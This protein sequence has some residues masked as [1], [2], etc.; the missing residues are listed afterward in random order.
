VLFFRPTILILNVITNLTMKHITYLII[1]VLLASCGNQ[2]VVDS[3][4]RRIGESEEAQKKFIL[5]VE[6][7]L[8]DHGVE[9]QSLLA[10]RDSLIAFTSSKKTL[11]NES[12]N[13]KSV[14]SAVKNWNEDLPTIFETNN[15][16]VLNENL[17]T[18][19]MGIFA[20]FEL[21][22]KTNRVLEE[23]AKAA[24]PKEAR[25]DFLKLFFEPHLTE[26]KF[27]EQYKGK[28]FFAATSKHTPNIINISVNGEK[29]EFTK[30]GFG[31]FTVTPN[32]RG[33]FK[34]TA[35]ANGKSGTMSQNILVEKSISIKVK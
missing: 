1:S 12:K 22:E 4:N 7:T 17:P 19:L 24:V 27:G 29:V 35:V 34:M 6:R 21:N 5:N 30:E 14:I 31:I 25:Y 10:K 3:I 13:T 28:I 26:L 9:N 18:D 33:I 15:T 8:Q 32:K 11:I 20:L 2:A 23:M 16:A